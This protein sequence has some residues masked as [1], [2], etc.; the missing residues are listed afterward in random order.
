MNP[1]SY[2]QSHIEGNKKCKIQCD[3]CREYYKPLEE[4]QRKQIE[5]EFYAQMEEDYC[6]QMQIEADKVNSI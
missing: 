2:C 6:K 5:Q 1:F 3:H 4:E